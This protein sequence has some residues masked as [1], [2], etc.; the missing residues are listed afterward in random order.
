MFNSLAIAGLIIF[1]IL[2]VAFW[3]IFRMRRE[4]IEHV[5]E[6][7]RTLSKL[8]EGDRQELL[9]KLPTLPQE[10]KAWDLIAWQLSFWKPIA[11]PRN[12]EFPQIWSL[13][14]F[15]FPHKLREQVYEPVIEE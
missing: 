10:L 4:Q 1:E 14:A 15:L 12:I 3:S 5:L 7:L 8:S 11:P 9:D 13:A 2:L 6:S